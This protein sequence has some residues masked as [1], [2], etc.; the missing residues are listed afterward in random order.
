MLSI[1][2]C[3]KVVQQEEVII[4]TMEL[5]ILKDPFLSFPSE[6]FYF[7]GLAQPSRM[8]YAY[9]R[10]LLLTRGSSAVLRSSD[11]EVS[12]CKVTL[13]VEAKRILHPKLAPLHH[14]KFLFSFFPNSTLVFM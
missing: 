9:L 12:A 11:R 3:N 8:L 6:V 1:V 4:D 14:S 5:L 7:S 10:H 2:E 13:M